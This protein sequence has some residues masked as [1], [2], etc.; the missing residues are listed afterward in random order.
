[1]NKNFITLH[2]RSVISISG[3]DR[4]TFLQGL[5]TNDINKVSETQAIYT[6]MLS[7]QGRF[8]YDFF[9]IAD[10]EKLLLDCCKERV[11]EIVQKFSFYKL[12][13]KVEIKKEDLVVVS[14]GE[15]GFV[16]PRDSEM[17]FRNFIVESELQS[18]AAFVMPT[19]SLNQINKE[20]E[21]KVGIANADLQGAFYSTNTTQPQSVIP[22]KVGCVIPT[23]V[24]CV[25][26][27]KVG[28]HN[29]SRWIPTFVGMTDCDVMTE[30]DLMTENNK[31]Q[32]YS[33]QRINLKLPDDSDL[34][35][36]KSF[37][38]EFGFDNFNAIDYQ[39]GCYVGQETTARTHYKGIIRKK[40]FLVEIIDCNQIEKGTEIEAEDKKIGEILSSVFAENKLLALALIKN[41][42]NE[43]KEINLG[44]LKL[45]A[46][47][48][49]IKTIKIIK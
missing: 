5:I 17:G 11:D 25:I 12:R 38:L 32:N 48:Q 43:G 42:D 4:K 33:L 20:N 39:K 2:N 3:V 31:M 21:H 13:S 19:L 34:T 7:P 15:I 18:E 30:S 10:G 46:V 24:G 14:G 40:I 45:S 49:G 29:D 1:M 8:L 16:D 26:P 22:T 6:F 44:E 41:L 36:D 23:K 35:Y 47:S 37:P 9:I 28:I 27:T